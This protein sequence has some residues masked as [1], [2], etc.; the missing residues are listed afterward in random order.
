MA[1]KGKFSWGWFISWWFIPGPGPFFYA[2]Y[3]FTIKKKRVVDLYLEDGKVKGRYGP[4]ALTLEA[5]KDTLTKDTLTYEM[6][7]AVV[8]TLELAVLILIALAYGQ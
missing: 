3:H 5:P 2:V 1:P 4:G 8:V 7:V 6:L